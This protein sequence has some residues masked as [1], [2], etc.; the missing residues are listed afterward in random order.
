MKK[1]VLVIDED[2]ERN[3]STV[4]L[5]YLVRGFRDR[6]YDVVVLTWKYRAPDAAGLKRS[7][8]LID[9]RIGFVTTI[10]LCVH[11]AYSMSPFS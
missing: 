3:G 10:T 1:R 9:G 6:G 11:F 2:Q 5:E 8:T 4:S 7:A